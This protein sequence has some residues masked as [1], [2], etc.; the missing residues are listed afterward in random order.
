MAKDKDIV[1]VGETE[2]KFFKDVVHETLEGL[3]C[4][5]ETK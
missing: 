3:R 4:V 1:Q 5:S 2:M